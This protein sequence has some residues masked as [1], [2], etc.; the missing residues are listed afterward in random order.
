MKKQQFLK[1]F[2]INFIILLAV[3]V[4]F[5]YF[6]LEEINFLPEILSALITAIL[7]TLAFMYITK[8]EH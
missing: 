1:N 5:N 8:T 2:A 6:T 3:H 7:L 4:I